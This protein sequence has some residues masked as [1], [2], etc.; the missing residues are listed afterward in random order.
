M[1]SSTRELD[2]ML[3]SNRSFRFSF[4]LNDAPVA[5]GWLAGV[6]I[7][8]SVSGANPAAAQ[9]MD[10]LPPPPNVTFGETLPTA[11]PVPYRSSSSASSRAATQDAYL[12]FV[13]GNS[14]LMLQQVRAI[15]PSADYREHEGRTVIDAG[16]F[17]Q[18]DDANQQIAQL[19]SRGIGAGLDRVE[20]AASGASANAFAGTG[21]SA[22]R[23]VE[24]GQSTVAAAPNSGVPIPVNQPASRRQSD[25]ASDASANYFVVV[26]SNGENVQTISQYVAQLALDAPT[27]GVQI[28]SHLGSHVRVGPFRDRGTAQNWENYLR[29]FGMDARVHYRR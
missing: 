15:V 19:E 26:P 16:I 11:T 3:L 13:N 22:P 28:G 9:V 4:R 5:C 8:A 27:S 7:A 14:P 1:N 23:E 12:V 10:Q 24:F 6:A 18:Q 17:Q 21:G 29:A 20:I 25:D 2:A